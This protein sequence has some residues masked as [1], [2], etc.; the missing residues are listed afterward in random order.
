MRESRRQRHFSCPKFAK[1]HVRSP[2]L[3]CTGHPWCRLPCPP[4]LC[5]LAA[6]LF[7]AAPTTCSGPRPPSPP[8][9]ALQLSHPPLA[10][11]HAHCSR[12]A[13][14]HARQS[15]ASR[16]L[17]ARLLVC[18]LVCSLARLL[19]HSPFLTCRPPARPSTSPPQ[20][21]DCPAVMG[22]RLVFVSGGGSPWFKIGASICQRR[23]RQ[24]QHRRRRRRSGGGGSGLA[25]ASVAVPRCPSCACHSLRG[26]VV[27]DAAGGKG[28][29]LPARCAR[30]LRRRCLA[31]N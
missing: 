9:P 7:A 30:R 3:H 24:Q 28:S 1:A 5:V 19:A 11:W 13:H 17:A 8:S 10:P 27:A 4:L 26:L 29:V 23:Q 12:T 14:S 6:I 31:S 18:S 16:L 25:V 22:L 2:C 15:L 20:T 21:H